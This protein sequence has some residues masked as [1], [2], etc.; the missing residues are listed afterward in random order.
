MLMNLRNIVKRSYYCQL[1]ITTVGSRLVLLVKVCAAAEVLKD[2]L[3]VISTARVNESMK[4][5]NVL[6][7]PVGNKMLQGIPTASYDV[8]PASAL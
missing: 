6:D 4:S 1:N 8:S 7:D 2:L 5:I 3:Q